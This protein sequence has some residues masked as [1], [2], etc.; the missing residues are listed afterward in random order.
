MHMQPHVSAC[1][2]ATERDGRAYVRVQGGAH[3]SESEVSRGKGVGERSK[4]KDW[5]VQWWWKGRAVRRTTN[6]ATGSKLGS[7]KD[8]FSCAITASGSDLP[9]TRWRGTG[10]T[11]CSAAT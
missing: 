5:L 7:K 1:D 3:C 11:G 9:D 2:E 4:H 10:S 8:L 6:S